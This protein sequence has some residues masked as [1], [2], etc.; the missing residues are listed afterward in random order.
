MWNPHQV[1]YTP[2]I[3]QITVLPALS[4]DCLLHKSQHGMLRAPFPVAA[5]EAPPPSMKKIYPSSQIGPNDPHCF[6]DKLGLCL[7]WQSYGRRR[8]AVSLICRLL[9]PDWAQSVC[10]VAASRLQQLRER[11][12]CGAIIMGC[13]SV[14]VM[15]F[16]NTAERLEAPGNWGR[17]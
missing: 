5:E 12:T 15:A 4:L 14:A 7:Q 6:H 17:K 2:H 16:A 1:H 13:I 10:I 3:L 9:I 8:T 11:G